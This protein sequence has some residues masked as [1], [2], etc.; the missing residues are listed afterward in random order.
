LDSGNTQKITFEINQID[1]L[2]NESKPLFDLCKL[3][4]P[5]FVERCGIAL[6][7]QSF[8]NGVENILLLIIKHKDASLPNGTKWHKELFFKA[9]EKTENRTNILR[10]EL[11]IH[12]N[13]YL[14]FRH[15]VRHS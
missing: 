15:F 14:E 13:D 7:L 2:I 8:Y 9:F 5:D 11:K 12:L 6:I 4:E 3:K 10:D 1:Q